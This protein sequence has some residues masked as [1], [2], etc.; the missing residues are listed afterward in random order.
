MEWTVPELV[1]KG[2]AL[3]IT[4]VP[5]FVERLSEKARTLYSTK[6]TNVIIEYDHKDHL[7]CVKCLSYCAFLS[8]VVHF[9]AD[10][11]PDRYFDEMASIFN[12]LAEMDLVG[13]GVLA[14]AIIL[15]L[16]PIGGPRSLLTL[17]L[18]PSHRLK[19]AA[20]LLWGMAATPDVVEN[21]RRLLNAVLG[22]EAFVKEGGIG[23]DKWGCDG[24]SK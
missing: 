11:I 24:G 18:F 4:E 10:E 6:Q 13:F 23:S 21:E 1:A 8:K 2:T 19:K 9:Q 15:P 3:R 12:S 22:E 14:P 20:E 16:A 5:R 7:G 17:Y